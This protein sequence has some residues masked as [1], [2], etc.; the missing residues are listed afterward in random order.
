M[1]AWIKKTWT[2]SQNVVACT[3]AMADNDFELANE[4]FSK[5]E[6]SKS[7]RHIALGGRIRLGQR[8]YQDALQY[9]EKASRMALQRK[10]RHSR[11]VLEYCRFWI[12]L[13]KKDGKHE[14]YRDAAHRLKPTRAVLFCLPLA[15][16]EWRDEIDDSPKELMANFRYAQQK[17][18]Y[19][20]DGSI[21]FKSIVK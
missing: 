14:L 21:D 1:L 3:H 19:S 20:L 18:R 9:F 2:K 12:S 6:N 13:I 7:A 11:Y 8:D 5:F 16:K 10:N 4:L 17:S 15:P